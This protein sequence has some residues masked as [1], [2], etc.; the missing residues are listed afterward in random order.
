MLSRR[1]KGWMTLVGGVLIMLCIGTMYLWGNISIYVTSYYRTKGNPD[2]NINYAS[3]LFPFWDLSQAIGVIFI[4]YTLGKRIGY[5][6]Y[7]VLTMMVFGGAQYFSVTFFNFWQFMIFYGIIAP[8]A[9][10][11]VSMVTLYCCWAYFPRHKGKVTGFIF[12]MFGL[13]TSIWNSLAT[14][15]VNPYKLNPSIVVPMGNNSFYY[16][17]PYVSKNLPYMI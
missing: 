10:G 3:Y 6:S 12:M 14:Y 1:T 11:S 17:G 7:A 5:R 13:A 15:L 16:F 9:G 2:L 8:M 4:S